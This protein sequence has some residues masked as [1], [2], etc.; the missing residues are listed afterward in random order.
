MYKIKL[1]LK[2]PLSFVSYN[3]FKCISF[4]EYFMF[5]LYLKFKGFKKP[6]NEEIEFVCKNITIIYKSFE[7]QKMAKRLYKNIQKYYPDIQVIIVDD[8]KKPLKIKGNNLEVLQL[9]FNSGLSYGLNCAL[10]KVKTPYVLRLD[11]DEL[12]TRKTMLGQQLNF[13]EEHEEIDLVGFCTLTAIRCKN[14]VKI[15][16]DYIKFT[17]ELAPKPLKIPHLT[18][19]D[20]THIVMGKVPNII[21]VQTDKL[22]E[23]G[24]DNNIRMLDHNDFFWRAAGNIVTVLALETVVFHYHNPFDKYYQKFREDVMEDSK[25]IYLKNVIRIN[26]CKKKEEN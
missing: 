13:L 12:L 20:E 1:L 16:N 23:V 21:L 5:D 2:G 18:K 10:E 25:Y 15:C 11:D 7:R 24:W 8:S 17:M 14:P 26:E 6:D 3:F 4:I 9:P 22:R 19:I